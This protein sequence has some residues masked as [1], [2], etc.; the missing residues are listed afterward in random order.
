MLT[1]KEKRM[2]DIRGELDKIM[3]SNDLD[4]LRFYARQALVSQLNELEAETATV[5]AHGVT[6]YSPEKRFELTMEIEDIFGEG[7]AKIIARETK[8]GTSYVVSLVVEEDI[9]RYA[10]ISDGITRFGEIMS[11]SSLV[12]IIQKYM[13]CDREMIGKKFKVAITPNTF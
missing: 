2:Q 5:V 8:D 9:S 7:R 11:R 13:Y 3:D 4:S 12:E 1:N 6:T 10:D